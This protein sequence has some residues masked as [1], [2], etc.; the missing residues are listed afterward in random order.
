MPNQILNRSYI[1]R[2]I[3]DFYE[4]RNNQGRDP[5]TIV[6]NEQDRSIIETIFHITIGI[7]YDARVYGMNIA[8]GD[9]IKRGT[10][11]LS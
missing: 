9:H 3:T 6:I 10:V 4:N 8:C 1:D 11:E 5:I 7:G 2:K